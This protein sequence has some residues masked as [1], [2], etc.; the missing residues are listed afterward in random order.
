MRNDLPTIFFSAAPALL[1]RIEGDPV[2]RTVPGTELQR[3]VNTTAL[4][5]RDVTGMCYLKILDGWMEAYSL[6]ANWWSVSVVG[7]DLGE[8]ALRQAVASKTVDLVDR[9]DPKNATGMSSLA[10]G[11]APVI[12]IS[13]TPAALIVT[14]GPMKFAPIKGTSLQYVVNTSA[15]V[16]R[17]PTDQELYLLTSGRWFRSWNVEGPW[18][19]VASSELPADFAR[20][21]DGSPKARVKASVTSAPRHGSLKMEAGR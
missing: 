1:V 2:Y 14:D 9:V 4:I 17:E 13:T 6:D 19:L 8:V 5:V 11:P 12:F 21:P 3:V 15:D 20:I 18:Q 7:P 10:N 16:F